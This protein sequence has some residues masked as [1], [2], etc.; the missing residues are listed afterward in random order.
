MMAD[1]QADPV[2]WRKTSFKGKEAEW[3]KKTLRQ[4]CACLSPLSHDR[5]VGRAPPNRK[6]PV[7]IRPKVTA[8]S[9]HIQDMRLI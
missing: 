9:L 4:K 2:A 3:K 5:R 7:A 6:G 8:M 1:Q